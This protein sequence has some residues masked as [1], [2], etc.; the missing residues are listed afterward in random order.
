MIR[1]VDL[2]IPLLTWAAMHDP[3]FPKI[4]FKP[5]IAITWNSYST[6]IYSS[7]RFTVSCTRGWL[8]YIP[9]E[10]ASHYKVDA[11]SKQVN[12]DDFDDIPF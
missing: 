2:N 12:H 5:P 6:E 8:V 10:V 7:V 11:R 1:D 9:W 3:S 4:W